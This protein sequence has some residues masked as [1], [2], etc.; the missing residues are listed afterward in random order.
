MP[1]GLEHVYRALYVG[2]HIFARLLDRGYDV[3]DTGEVEHVPSAGEE[4][5]V[6]RKGADVALIED[7][8]RIHLVLRQVRRAATDEIIDDADA[9]TSLDK[10]IDHVA[11]DEPG[12]TRDHG[13]RSRGHQD[14]RMRFSTL[15]LW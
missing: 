14:T 6:G 15:T 4:L 13:K 8:L 9:E 7:D 10:K 12:A 11:A 2:R 1:R 5:V 3:P